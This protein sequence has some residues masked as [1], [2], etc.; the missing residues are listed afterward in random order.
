MASRKYEKLK[1]Q[2]DIAISD[3]KNETAKLEVVSGEAKRVA[4][5][6]RDVSIILGDLDKQFE[7]ATK[8]TGVD[9][10]FLFFATALQ[11]IRQYFLTPFQERQNDKLSEKEAKKKEKEILGKFDRN[12]DSN[13]YGRGRYFASKEDIFMKGVPY[14]VQFGS[15]DFDLKLSGNAHRSRTLG[16]DPLFGWIF[17]TSNI[18]TNTLT[19]WSFRSYHVKP[20]PM[21]NGRMKAKIVE[22]AK[23]PLM[24]EYAVKRTS[25]DP[26]VLAMA[27]IKQRLHLKSDMFSI[28][29]LPIPGVMTL[30]PETAEELSKY[31]IDFGNAM[32]IGKQI[33]YS[34]FINTLTAIIHGLFYDESF[35][36]KSLYE[37][38]TRKILSYSNLIAS[39]S[40]IIGV[41]IA[42]AVAAS[43]GN[44]QLGKDAMR[45]LDVG[46]FAVTIYRI[47]NDKKFIQQIKQEFLEKEFYNIVMGEEIL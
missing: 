41:A 2:K 3:I 33:T 47:V 42:E 17:G 28:A 37:V 36:S 13:N 9:I 10:S 14:D 11:C 38:R 15:P 40:N 6:S 12:K 7:E 32:I 20:A 19:D 16:H 22:R 34:V 5:V 29:G 45:Y 23:T 18:M 8:L 4:E 21:A 44:T 26:A 1:K 43:T 25:E 27:V 24:L 31:G 35:G 39:A 30:S 46:G